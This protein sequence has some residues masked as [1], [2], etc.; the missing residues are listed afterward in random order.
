MARS[1]EDWATEYMLRF[2]P[3]AYTAPAHPGEYEFLARLRDDGYSFH[4]I[5]KWYQRKLGHTLCDD[6]I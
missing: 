2:G 4:H 1:L 5:F 6:W 3:I